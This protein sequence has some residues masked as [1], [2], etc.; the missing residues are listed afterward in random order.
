MQLGFSR[1]LKF[2]RG[3]VMVALSFRGWHLSARALQDM[4][5]LGSE[6]LLGTTYTCSFPAK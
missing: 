3:E 1:L 5:T 6:A 4:E 2:S